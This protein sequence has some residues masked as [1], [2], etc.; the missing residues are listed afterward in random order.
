MPVNS[1]VRI[2]LNK[3][4]QQSAM[5]PVAALV[6]QQFPNGGNPFLTNFALLVDYDRFVADATDGDIIATVPSAADLVKGKPYIVEKKGGTNAVTVTFTD[7]DTFFGEATVALTGDGDTF[8]FISD[9]TT[10]KSAFPSGTPG[11]APAGSLAADQNLADLDDVVE[12][13]TN[14]GVNKVYLPLRVATLVGTGVY[15]IRS[16]YAGTITS[17]TSITEGVLTT[18]DATLTGK[19]ATVDITDGVI[20]ITQVGSAAGDKDAATPSALN[21]VAVDDEISLTVGGTNATATV[22]NCWIEITLS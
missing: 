7:P 10:I 22:A 2:P 13:R 8:A 4:M 21:V 1:Q 11:V 5:S 18:G 9:G 15:R 6:S 12:A 16:P 19:I 14:L 3:A 20:T 17:I